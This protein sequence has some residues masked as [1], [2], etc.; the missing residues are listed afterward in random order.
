MPTQ[1]LSTPF[2]QQMRPM[3][4][5]MYR[6]A[7]PPSTLRSSPAQA[8]PTPAQTPPPGLANATGA[9]SQSVASSLLQSVAARAASAPEGTGR[10]PSISSLGS[11][12]FVSTNPASFE[13]ILKRH[14]GVIALFVENSPAES[15]LEVAFETLAKRKARSN[16]VTFVRVDVKVGNAKEVLAMW[17]PEKT[18]SVVHFLKGEKVYRCLKDE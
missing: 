1:F 2:G 8:Y 17:G 14:R 5:S 11:H 6:R 4:D 16:Q 10:D 3:I 18:P 7:P 15:E 12:L 13:S 9:H